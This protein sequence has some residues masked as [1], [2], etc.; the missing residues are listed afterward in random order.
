MAEPAKKASPLLPKD[1]IMLHNIG[2]KYI[3]ET[4][5]QLF[6][7]FHPI[8]KTSQENVATYLMENKHRSAI[9]HKDP[10]NGFGSQAQSVMGLFINYDAKKTMQNQEKKA[11]NMSL[12]FTPEHEELSSSVAVALPEMK[13]K[14]L[15]SNFVRLCAVEIKFCTAVACLGHR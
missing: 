14:D 7:D 13:G 1:W 9:L 10:R 6:W 3:A 11:V 4:S 15:V 5:D 12:E 8:A 2:H